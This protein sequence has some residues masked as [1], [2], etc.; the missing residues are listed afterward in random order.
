MSKGKHT[1]GCA[2]CGRKM[3]NG[4]C[5]SCMDELDKNWRHYFTPVPTETTDHGTPSSLSDAIAR[6]LSPIK[7]APTTDDFLRVRAAV[8]AVLVREFNIGMMEPD[9]TPQADVV[10]KRLFERLMESGE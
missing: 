6:S 9:T 2:E 3:K 8:R 5:E 1:P 7:G 10:L 4:F